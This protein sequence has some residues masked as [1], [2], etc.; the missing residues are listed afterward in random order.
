[1]S[2]QSLPAQDSGDMVTIGSLAQEL[3]L[4]NQSITVAARFML[5]ETD[6][7][8]RELNFWLR[9]TMQDHESSLH[10]PMFSD[11]LDTHLLRVSHALKVLKSL[12][13]QY[14]NRLIEHAETVGQQLKEKSIS[15]LSK[16]LEKINLG[17]QNNDLS[18]NLQEMKLN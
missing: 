16:E 10:F 17:P 7:I 1:M 18:F 15:Q 8:K 13:C 3:E 12:S 5:W 9:C 11:A 4:L 14:T 2:S 6:D